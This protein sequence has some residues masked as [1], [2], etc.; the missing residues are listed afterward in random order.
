MNL[1]MRI[2]TSN[3]VSYSRKKTNKEA[4]TVTLTEN[5]KRPIFI[6]HKKNDER[7]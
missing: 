3:Q 7:C 1:K 2:H 4:N 5:I 6:L